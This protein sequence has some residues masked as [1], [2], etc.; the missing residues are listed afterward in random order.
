MVI[1]SH[2]VKDELFCVGGFL[3]F[4]VTRELLDS[5]LPGLNMKQIANEEGEWE[6]NSSWEASS[7]KW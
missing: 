6:K 1:A 3:E 5:V 2:M 7:W 4:P